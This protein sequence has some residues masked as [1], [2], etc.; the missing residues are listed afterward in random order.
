SR[1]FST[2]IGSMSHAPTV[3]VTP[4]SAPAKRPSDED[5]RSGT[6]YQPPCAS[7][8]YSLFAYA[9]ALGGNAKA[10]KRKVAGDIGAGV[11]ENPFGVEHAASSRDHFQCL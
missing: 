3:G 9:L 11:N 10:P 2:T 6:R 5:S 4:R 7:S 1:E 8:D